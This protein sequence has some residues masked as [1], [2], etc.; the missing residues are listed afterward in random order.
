MSLQKELKDAA[1]VAALR[2]PKHKPT[3]PQTKE[4]KKSSKKNLCINDI[5]QP[6]S[7]TFLPTEIYDAY[8]ANMFEHS[9][10]YVLHTSLGNISIR[11][12]RIIKLHLKL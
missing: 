6:V 7:I 12:S 11:D 3:T 1:R 4:E 5:K 9:Y 10:S 2:I 8:P